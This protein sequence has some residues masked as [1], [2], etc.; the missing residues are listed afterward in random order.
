[1]ISPFNSIKTEAKFTE[2]VLIEIFIMDDCPLQPSNET[3]S[4]MRK[5]S[6]QTSMQMPTM[7]FSVLVQ[8]YCEI[9]V[10]FRNGRVNTGEGAKGV[11]YQLGC[12]YGYGEL[13]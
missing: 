3:G 1:M 6:M 12:T 2:L 11:I 7:I 13:K 5:Q 9:D 4:M 8:K 10:W